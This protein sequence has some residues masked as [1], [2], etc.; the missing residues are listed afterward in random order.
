MNSRFDDP[1]YGSMINKK[2]EQQAMKRWED[3]LPDYSDHKGTP[4]SPVQDLADREL[5]PVKQPTMQCCLPMTY[6]KWMA[7][8]EWS[9]E[10][11]NRFKAQPQAVD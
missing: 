6:N 3:V 2:A 5:P 8:C 1:S 9:D 4:I 7:Y 11:D 10:Y